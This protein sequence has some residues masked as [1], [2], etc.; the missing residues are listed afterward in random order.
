MRECL[1]YIDPG[2]GSMLFTILISI[3]GFLIYFFRIF[4][5]KIK[6]II[7]RG[8]MDKIDSNKIPVLIF[9]EAKRYWSVFEPICRELNERG[10]DVTY[11]TTSPDDPAL[12][13]KRYEHVK[14]EFIGEGNKAFAK[15]NVVNASVLV[16]STPGLEVYQWKRSKFVDCYVHV[17]HASSEIAG[18]R[19]FGTDY[20]DVLL[21]SGQYQIDDVRELENLRHLPAKEI[22]LVGIPYMDEMKKRI[23]PD[24]NKNG[25][26]TVLLAPS[27]GAN[28][29]FNK[30]GTAVIE[31]L[32]KCDC[33][34]IARPH[35]QSFISDADMMK[36]L[37]AKYPDRDGFKWD[38]SSDNF[39]SLN[40]ADIMI[41]DFSG[42]IFD[43]SLVFDKPIIYADTEFNTDC[44]DFYCLSHQPWTLTVL[45]KLG[46]KLS[47]GNLGE[48]DQMID[49][50]LTDESFKEGRDEVRSETWAHMGEGAKRTADFIV[51]KYESIKNEKAQRDQESVK[52]SKKMC[53]SLSAS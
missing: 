39:E 15:L 12:S 45:P 50:C 21:L 48:L 4:W 17:L 43:F 46:I 42:I 22:E 16:S 29:I 6:F 36:D 26:R 23:S 38:L 1:L 24:K 44:Y 49:K 18:D 14:A 9:A 30:Y 27:W 53:D 2:T 20:Y 11:W 33:D 3:V 52:G 37:M 8:K 13:Q 35:P 51:R 5:I 34:I 7:S 47:N 31:E 25:R 19:M 40:A 41:S 28:S 32:L 10:T